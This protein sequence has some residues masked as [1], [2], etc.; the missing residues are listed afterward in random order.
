MNEKVTLD[1]FGAGALRERFEDALHATAMNVMDPNTDPT[2]TRTV[3][4]TVRVKP[5]QSRRSASATV[6]VVTKP[7]PDRAVEDIL[8]FHMAGGEPLVTRYDPGQRTL[9]DEVESQAAD[10]VLH[11][12]PAAHGGGS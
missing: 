2:A 3:V 5:H 12:R 1:T 10:G 8:H 6:Q 4:I 7:A 9:E 11:M